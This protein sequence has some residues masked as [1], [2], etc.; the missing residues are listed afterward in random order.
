[1]AERM[2]GTVKWIN[3]A[4]GYGFLGRDFGEDVFVHFSAIQQEGNRRLVKGQKV[5]FSVEA[6]PQGLHAVNVILIQEYT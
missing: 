6:G 3:I 5:A 2:I 1:M 4:K